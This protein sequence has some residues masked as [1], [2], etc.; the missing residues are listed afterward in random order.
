MGACSHAQTGLPL[1]RGR[2]VRSSRLLVLA[3][4]AV[5]L[6][7]ADAPRPDAK[8]LASNYTDR[9][10]AILSGA[11]K[12]EVFRL[13]GEDLDL[14]GKTQATGE[15]RI[16]GYR[17]TGQGPDQGREFAVRLAAV[18]SD[19]KTY[20]DRFAACFWPGVAFR[21]WKD[22]ECVEV[23]ICFKCQNFY[24][25]PP[26]EA[27]METASF[28]GSPARQRLLR[29]AKEAFPNDAEVQALR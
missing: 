26:K 8:G 14:G 2:T 13:D 18:L 1:R 16:G 15:R 19:E 11:T 23:L 9:T 4:A 24:C 3:V 27:A 17:V 20:T 28:S 22:E 7:C 21:V 29:L 5:L 6:G 12:V 10:K 25:G